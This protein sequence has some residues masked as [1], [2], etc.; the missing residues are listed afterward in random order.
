MKLIN[1]T[2]CFLAT[3]GLG[4]AAHGAGTNQAAPDITVARKCNFSLTESQS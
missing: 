4:F 2:T 3:A 1:R